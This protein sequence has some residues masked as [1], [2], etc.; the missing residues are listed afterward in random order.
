MKIIGRKQEIEML[1]QCYK[2]EKSEF[3]GIFGRRRVGKTFLV[4]EAMAERIT[5]HVTGI[6]QGSRRE[7]LDSFCSAVKKIDVTSKMTKPK[8]WL[9][10]F[11]MLRNALDKIPKTKNNKKV[12]F[13]DEMPWMDTPKSGFLSALEH[14]WNNYAAW[15]HDIMLIVC[16]S[17]TSWIVKKIIDNRG[18]L[19]NRLTKRIHLKPFTLAETE[20]FLKYKGIKWSRYDIAR[21][22]MTMGGI[23]YY[24]DYLTAGSQGLNAN[25]D[26][27]FFSEYAPLREE[28]DNLFSSIFQNHKTHVKI[29]EALAKK[30]GGLTR[31]EIIEKTRMKTSGDLS[32]V[33]SDLEVCGFIR[34]Y[35]AYGKIERG[36]VYQLVDFYSLFYLH[37]VK[38]VSIS[39]DKHWSTIANSAKVSSWMGYS[40]EILCLCHVEQIRA[41]LGFSSVACD[42]S[43]WRSEKNEDTRGAQIDLVI[44]RTD[45]IVNLCE[46]KFSRNEFEITKD[47]EMLLANKIEQFKNQTKT[48]SAL[49]L[50]MITANGVKNNIHSGIVDSEVVLDNLF[51]F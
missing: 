41:A 32:E 9:E 40:F 2:S 46:M 30:N 15:E 39:A 48:K 27:L 21:C 50:T 19:H 20:E 24:L 29:I 26:D 8:D 25:I 4:R 49:H 5:L 28:Y 42:Y 34:R 1:E 7:Q 6:F 23:P 44:D 51:K 36:A 35:N 38:G 45:R 31:K 18:G 12:L 14:F 37:F 10:A 47:Y 22:Y 33:L 13:L 17:A 16:G 3:V 11:E 43:A